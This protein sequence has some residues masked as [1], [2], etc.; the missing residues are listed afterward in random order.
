M[1]LAIV[2]FFFV[3]LRVLVLM[4]VVAKTFLHDFQGSFC[5]NIFANKV[6]IVF[7]FGKGTLSL[8]CMC[9]GGH[10]VYKHSGIFHSRNEREDNSGSRMA[11]LD[12]ST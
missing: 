3:V 4:L 11:L 8:K 2:C 7:H 9:I 5:A 10:P 12:F 1:F 6:G